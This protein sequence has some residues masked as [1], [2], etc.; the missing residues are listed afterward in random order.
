MGH[1]FEGLQRGPGGRAPLLETPK[2]ML[3]KTQ[4]FASACIGAL[5]LGNLEG[6]AVLSLSLLI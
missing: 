4:K 5:L 3:S 6:G 1:V 2:D